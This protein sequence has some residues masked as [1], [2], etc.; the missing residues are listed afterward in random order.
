MKYNTLIFEIEH[1]MKRQLKMK[2]KYIKMP[3]MI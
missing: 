2:F 1:N 3:I